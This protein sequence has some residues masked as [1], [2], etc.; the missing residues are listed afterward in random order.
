MIGKI[1]SA[2][3]FFSCWEKTRPFDAMKQKNVL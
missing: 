3:E 2:G 1:L